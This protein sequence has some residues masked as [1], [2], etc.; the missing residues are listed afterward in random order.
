MPDAQWLKGAGYGNVYVA[1]TVQPTG[2]T[3]TLRGS[4]PFLTTTL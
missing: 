3:C 1:S 2:Q 4:S